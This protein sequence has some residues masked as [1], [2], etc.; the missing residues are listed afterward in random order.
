MTTSLRLRVCSKLL[1]HVFFCSL[2]W[3]WLSYVNRR[4]IRVDWISSNVYY[5]ITAGIL[6]KIYM[7]NNTRTRRCINVKQKIIMKIQLA[8]TQTSFLWPHT[9]V[10][11]FLLNRL[12]QLCRQH[13]SSSTTTVFPPCKL[14]VL[15]RARSTSSRPVLRS[16]KFRLY[17]RHKYEIPKLPQ[18]NSM[19][20]STNY[21]TRRIQKLSRWQKGL[22]NPKTI[23][24]QNFQ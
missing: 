3:M 1:C 23:R 21:E 13:N 20:K 7:Y 2:S 11:L 14:D 24:H 5:N 18:N 10:Q 6:T 4:S 15:L 22:Q 17:K 8:K 12:T 19:W 16:P 9:S